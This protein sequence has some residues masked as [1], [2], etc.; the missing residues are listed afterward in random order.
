MMITETDTKQKRDE[1]ENGGR[2]TISAR[3]K[4]NIHPRYL[5]EHKTQQDSTYLE[6]WDEL[7]QEE[8]DGR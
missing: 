4:A 1:V 7:Q 3:R 8:D 2:K 6:D 5:R